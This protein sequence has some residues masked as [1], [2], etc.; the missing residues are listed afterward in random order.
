MNEFNVQAKK[1]ILRNKISKRASIFAKLKENY[2]L[3]LSTEFFDKF[4]ER[5]E[6]LQRKVSWL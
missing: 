3:Y 2:N 5:R 4:R 6:L 1:I